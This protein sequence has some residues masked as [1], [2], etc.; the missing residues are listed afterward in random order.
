MPRTVKFE[1]PYL[2]ARKLLKK[3]EQDGF[4]DKS[5]EEYIKHLVKDIKLSHTT[6]DLIKE[7]TR[8]LLDMWMK[9]FADNLPYIR[10]GDELE[11]AIPRYEANNLSELAE[12]K[13]VNKAA[14]VIGR[15]PS[16]FNHKHLSILKAA[17]DNGWK[18][19]IV[20]SDGILIE[21]LKNG[22]IPTLTVTVDGSPIIKKWYDNSLVR[23]AGNKIK[24]ALSV[25]VNHEVYQILRKAGCKVYWFYPTFDDWRNITS[26][27]KMQR[28]MTKSKYNPKELQT[29]QTGG[30]CGTCSWVMAVSLFKR[31][32]VAMIGF[33]FGYPEGTNLEDTPYFSGIM[34][35]GGVEMIQHAYAEVYH[36]VFK[37]KAYMDAVFKNYRQTFLSMVKKVP[38]SQTF[39]CTEGGTL[40][41]EKIKC[42]PFKEFLARF[43]R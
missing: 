35:S 42:V 30:N 33:D 27:T 38:Y 19:I 10:Y 34:E 7:T 23:K 11:M 16:L 25:T 31:K 39:N 1:L 17:I 22:V 2:V 24:T 9:N 37:T 41:G 14:V 6:V 5:L 13:P 32:H 3:K 28:L 21:C 4:G 20:A 12:K 40:F 36:P 29:L 43:R 8:K 18:G 26:W 15:G